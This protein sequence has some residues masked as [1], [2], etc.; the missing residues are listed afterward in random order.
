MK[1]RTQAYRIKREV[2]ADMLMRLVEDYTD[3]FP[4]DIN[5]FEMMVELNR[6]N[7]INF[8]WIENESI[9]GAYING[10]GFSSQ[11]FYFRLIDDMLSH[12]EMHY[13]GDDD[14]PIIE[15]I[16]S[17][18][19]DRRDDDYR[20]NEMLKEIVECLERKSVMVDF[21]HGGVVKT[22]CEYIDSYED[23]GVERRHQ[24]QMAMNQWEFY[25]PPF[26]GGMKNEIKGSLKYQFNDYNEF[27]DVITA[28]KDEMLTAWVVDLVANVKNAS[29]TWVIA[30]L[31]RGLSIS[32]IMEKE[33]PWNRGWETW[34]IKKSDIGYSKFSRVSDVLAKE[35]LSKFE[36]EDEIG[37]WGF[38]RKDVL[39]AI[40]RIVKRRRSNGYGGG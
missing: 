23:L 33:Y 3:Q 27:D 20:V 32:E 19:L 11:Q 40:R 8:N 25:E 22:M 38:S 21:E 28:E 7:N 37:R 16:V 14:L 29:R 30:R 18:S 12:Y 31:D 2:A 5:F 35:R 13:V 10:V 17:W 4:D 34:R 24:E 36:V 1:Y 9:L 39:K 15:L 6:E 26:R